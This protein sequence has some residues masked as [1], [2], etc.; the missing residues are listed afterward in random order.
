MKRRHFLQAT[1]A[2]LATLGFS[3]LELQ[4]QSLRYAK[5]LAQSTPRKRALLVGISDY[6]AIREGSGWAALPGAVNDVEMQRELLVHR[7]GFKPDDVRLITNENAKRENILHEF[8][9]LIQWAKP[10]DVIVIHYSGHG[11]TVDDPD[12]TFKDNLNGT[13]VPWDSDLPPGGGEVEDITSGTLFL[14]MAAL[15]TE[16]VTVVLDSCYAGGGTRG[17]LVIRSRPGQ[18]ELLLRGDRGGAMLVASP[19]ERAYQEQKLAELKLSRADWIRQRQAGLAKGVALVAAQRNQEAADATFA[20]DAHAGVFTYALTRYLWQQTR[21]EAMGTVLI[22]T[23]AKTER[24]LKTL[25]NQAATQTPDLQTKPNSSNQTQPTY[26]LSDFATRGQAAEAVVTKVEGNQVQILLN[27]VEPQVLETFGKGANLTLVNAQGAAIATVEITGR[28][29]LHAKG[30][31][32]LKTPGTIASGTLL[33]ERS[34]VIP[35]DWSLRIGLDPSLGSEAAIAKAEL[36][37]IQSRIEAVPLLQQEVHYILGRMTKPVY[38]AMQQRKLADI[39]AVGSLGLFY[40]GLEPLPESFGKPGESVAQALEQRLQP[41]FK[42]LLAGRLLKLML[43]P[44]S[45]RLN[46]KAAVRI[47]GA[48]EFAAQVVAVRGGQTAPLGVGQS[49]KQIRVNEKIQIVVENNEAKDLDCA[50]VFLSADGEVQP[51]PFTSIVPAKTAI[52]IPGNRTTVTVTPPLGMSEVM[53]VFSTTSL[54]QAITQLQVLSETRGDDRA[55]QA[56]STVNTLLDELVGGGR[57]GSSQTQEQR[58]DSQQM[59]ALSVTFEI[60]G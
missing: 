7:F 56:I 27:G 50:I 18:A 12:R 39:P 9:D 19:A 24:L 37:K 2:T 25:T 17:N 26:F 48:R 53:V 47:A 32:K 6:L 14:L 41:K 29:Q 22:A 45:T 57:R 23:K 34:R 38:D 20:G 51:L 44:T 5:V 11:S 33:Q 15:K 36:P 31:V 60:I 55:G 28:N 59:A 4:Q 35:S 52:E 21:N 16:N 43:N 30:T 10:G 49:A 13:L 3:Q 1:G 42:F 46:V 58:L 54:E 8:E 40:S